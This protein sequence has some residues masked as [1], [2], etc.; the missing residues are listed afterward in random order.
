VGD[1]RALRA[2]D[3]D[4]KEEKRYPIPAADGVTIDKDNSVIIA[5]VAGKVIAFSLACPHQ[6]TA[7]RWSDDDHEFQ[8]PKH[9]SHYRPDGVFIDG[10]AT[11]DMDRLPIRRDGA[12]LVV[13]ID[14]L[15]QQDEHP[16]EWGRAFVAV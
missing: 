6:N 9:K 4:K 12:V 7:L 14:S 5:R 3:G 8:C 11:R 16:D 1:A 13:D 15:I 10:R 2:R